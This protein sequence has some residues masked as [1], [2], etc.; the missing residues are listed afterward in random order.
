MEKF[1]LKNFTLIRTLIAIL[2]GVI[3][4]VVLIFIIS[5]FPGE[6]LKYFILGPLLSKSRLAN[7]IENAAPMIFCGVAISIAF[8]AKQFNIGAE[9][10]PP[11]VFRLT[12]PG[13]SIFPWFLWW[14]G[15]PE[16]SGVLSL[17]FS[18]R[19]G[20]PVSWFPR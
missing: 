8:R 5:Q 6:S 9:G 19:N 17:G 16:R 4:S 2:I 14:R 18:R 1:L 15:L 3:I 10:A 13:S 7:V 11:S 12:F 20:G